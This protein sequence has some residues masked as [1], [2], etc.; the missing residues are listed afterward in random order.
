MDEDKSVLIEFF[1]N[2]PNWRMIDFLMENCLQDFTKK[3]IARG[4]KVS[5]ASLYNHWKELEKNNVIKV[6]RT[7]GRV[8]LYQLDG[9]EPI[10]KQLRQICMVLMRKAA[11]EAE[12]EIMV[13]AKAGKPRKK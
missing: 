2:A 8:R 13:K 6:T 5:G 9:R 12:E 3:D 7:I 4:A 10:V 1:G 11:D